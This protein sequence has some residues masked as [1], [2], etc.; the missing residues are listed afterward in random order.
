MV[1]HSRT[2][3][4]FL[5]RGE[6]FVLADGVREVRALDYALDEIR[7]LLARPQYHGQPLIFGRSGSGSWTPLNKPATD[8]WKF[9]SELV[10][11]VPDHWFNTKLA[12]ALMGGKLEEF[13]CAVQ[14]KPVLEVKNDG[15]FRRSLHSPGT[16]WLDAALSATQHRVTAPTLIGHNWGRSTLLDKN[17]V[18]LSEQKP[19]PSI[20]IYTLG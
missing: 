18:H 7:K 13:G 4:A 17:G 6:W 16:M 19:R 15:I 11:E 9:V 2:Q 10:A 1:G 20:R 12:P 8:F 5:R 14:E 3:K